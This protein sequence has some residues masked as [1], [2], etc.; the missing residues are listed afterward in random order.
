[1]T[2]AGG[3]GWDGGG[4]GGGGGKKREKKDPAGTRCHCWWCL[5]RRPR[6]LRPDGGLLPR[7]WF[8]FP[9][10]PALFSLLRFISAILSS[11]LSLSLSFSLSLIL[12]YVSP[13]AVKGGLSF[14]GD[15][16]GLRLPVGGGGAYLFSSLFLVFFSES[17]KFP[18]P[19]DRNSASAFGLLGY[20]LTIFFCLVT[21][22]QRILGCTLRVWTTR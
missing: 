18:L 2:K 20:A 13:F 5:W 17:L 12:F 4:G 21:P 10:G 6:R 3:V 7:L 14:A 19:V 11:S 15:T 1:M 9:P 8:H 16:T 22:V